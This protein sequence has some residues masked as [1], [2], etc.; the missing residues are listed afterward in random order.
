MYTQHVYFMQSKLTPTTT[1]PI[2]SFL[3]SITVAVTLSATFLTTFA[4][5]NSTLDLFGT[6]HLFLTFDILCYF[7]LK[8]FVYSFSS[9][10]N[11]VLN[12]LG[13]LVFSSCWLNHL[14]P[15]IQLLSLDYTSLELI[16]LKLTQYVKTIIM[17][18]QSKR[19]TPSKGIKH[20]R[21]TSISTLWEVVRTFRR[22]VSSLLPPFI[23][24]TEWGLNELLNCHVADE[25]SYK[26]RIA[27]LVY[28][29]VLYTAKTH[30]CF[31]WMSY[32]NI[33][34]K[35]TANSS[36]ISGLIL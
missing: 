35:R 1:I 36:N 19:G 24:T 15:A 4:S 12:N 29:E 17:Q 10:P 3:T 26:G 34:N 27:N 2:N 22:P 13:N 11:L 9:M 25:A 33:S 21:Q 8:T 16:I 5:Y 18:C 32:I 30:N 23:E 6:S 7:R 31:S 28:A 20:T 14:F